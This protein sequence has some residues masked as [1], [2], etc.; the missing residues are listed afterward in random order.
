MKPKDFHF[1]NIWLPWYGN[2]DCQP[3]DG[4]NIKSNWFELTPLGTFID[5]WDERWMTK[6]FSNSLWRYM[7]QIR[8]NRKRGWKGRREKS[9]QVGYN[10]SIN[11]SATD[12]FQFHPGMPRIC[13]TTPTQ[14][15][16]QSGGGRG[17]IYNL[18]YKA[19]SAFLHTVQIGGFSARQPTSLG[20]LPILGCDR[21]ECRLCRKFGVWSSQ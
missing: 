20:I 11:Q 6:G 18:V 17:R 2:V 16:N 5:Y 10:Q 14:A 1:E 8:P 13:A 15:I 4:I 3:E 21:G 9:W 19:Y 12:L 7:D